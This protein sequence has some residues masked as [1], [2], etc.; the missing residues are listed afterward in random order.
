MRRAH[1]RRVAG[2]RISGLSNPPGSGDAT[3]GSGDSAAR[4]GQS[5]DGLDALSPAPA[6]TRGRLAAL[7]AAHAGATVSRNV[8]ADLKLKA[9]AFQ[10]MEKGPPLAGRPLVSALVVMLR[11]TRQSARLR[12]QYPSLLHRG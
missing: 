8:Q 4:P 7:R 10:D 11:V 3:I 1:R 2:D 5:P 6:I 12:S 9:G